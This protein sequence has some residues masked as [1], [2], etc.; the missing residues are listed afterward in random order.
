MFCI[1]KCSKMNTKSTLI[2]SLPARGLA[3][4]VAF[5]LTACGGGGGSGGSGSVPV[6][7]TPGGLPGAGP[8]VPLD[9]ALGA[10]YESIHNFDRTETDPVS[11]DVFAVRATFV[12]GPDFFFEGIPVKTADVTRNLSRNNVPYPTL[13][14]RSYFQLNPYKLIGTTFPGS[15]LYVVASNQLALPGSGKAGDSGR[16]YDTTTYDSS[17][18]T[19]VL[20]RSSQTWQINADTA[21]T[22]N[23]CI[24]STTTVTNVPGTK[25]KFECYKVDSSGNIV[26][27][28]FS[29]PG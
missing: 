12:P 24:N 2:K 1:I 10:L 27:L 25:V 5:V 7:P 21:T 26:S 18:K 8:T 9:S 23:L 22:V 6:V 14:E 17:S 29:I 19:V 15:S 13:A 11:R 16:F 4:A 3:L 28:A 20:A